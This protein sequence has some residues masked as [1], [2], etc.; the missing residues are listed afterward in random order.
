MFSATTPAPSD[1]SSLSVG[2]CVC[3]SSVWEVL[4]WVVSGCVG[5]CEVTGAGSVLSVSPEFDIPV[6]LMVDALSLSIW[7]QRERNK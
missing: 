6:S 5:G 7:R 3:S 4:V 1:G 2:G